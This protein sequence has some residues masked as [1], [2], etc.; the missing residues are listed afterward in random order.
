VTLASRVGG[1]RGWGLEVIEGIETNY[2]L[3]V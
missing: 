2:F 3:F 1:F